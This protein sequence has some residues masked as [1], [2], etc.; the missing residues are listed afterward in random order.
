[1]IAKSTI[2][3]IKE[4]EGVKHQ[5]YLDSAGLKTIGVGHLI[6]KGEN[7]TEINDEEVD[8]L[9]YI[10]LN[11]S[12]NCVMQSVKIQLNQNQIDALVSLVFNIGVNAFKRSTLLKKINENAGREIVAKNWNEWRMAGGVAVPG[13][14]NRRAKELSLYFKKD[15]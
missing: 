10:D 3:F 9:L 1:M 8:A 15:I 7:F 11:I 5:V 13:L 6:R 4:L 14:I 12:Y 2:E